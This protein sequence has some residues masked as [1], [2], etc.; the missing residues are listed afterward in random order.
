V[1]IKSSLD[2]AAEVDGLKVAAALTLEEKA[3]V[4]GIVERTYDACEQLGAVIGV[5]ESGEEDLHL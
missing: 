1:L 4:Q 5:D 2:L 3:R